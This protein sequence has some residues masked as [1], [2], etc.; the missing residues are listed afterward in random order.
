MFIGA[1]GALALTQAH[2]MRHLV[3]WRLAG[4][5][6]NTGRCTGSCIIPGTRGGA[7]VRVVRAIVHFTIELNVANIIYTVYG[8]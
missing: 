5:S 6:R 1:L 8:I 4:L 3:Y 2:L 7:T